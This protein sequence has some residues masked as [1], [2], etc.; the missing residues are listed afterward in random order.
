VFITRLL[1]REKIPADYILQMKTMEELVPASSKLKTIKNHAP[2]FF[3]F[4]V[5][6]PAF[7][8]IQF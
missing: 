4:R 5:K 6:R 1:Q 2:D 8:M 3:I 7:G